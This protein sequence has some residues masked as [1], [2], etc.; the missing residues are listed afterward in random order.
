MLKDIFELLLLLGHSRSHESLRVGHSTPLIRHDLVS[1]LLGLRDTIVVSIL[2]EGVR[3]R[4]GL[5]V[6]RTGAVAGPSFSL[7][8]YRIAVLDC[9]VGSACDQVC[10]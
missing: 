3:L 9:L 2:N 8:A 5:I 6:F 7:S 4:D 1:L 10:V